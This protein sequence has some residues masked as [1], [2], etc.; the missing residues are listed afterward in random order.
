VS[1]GHPRTVGVKALP[2]PPE[3]LQ[4]N[5]CGNAGAALAAQSAAFYSVLKVSYARHGTPPLEQATILDF[6]CGWGRLTRLF[7][8][9][10][11]PAR[12][13]GC[14][15]DKEIL[16]WCDGLP[17]TFRQSEIRL[18][19]LPFDER[20]DLAFAFSVFTHLGPATH[21]SAL[22]AL[23]EALAPDGILIATIRPR[24]F[25]EMR[26]SE[27]A[28]LSIDRVRRLLDSYDA[29]E[30]VYLPY[31]LPPVEGEVPYGEAVVPDSYLE[32]HWQTRFEIL[33]RPSYGADP[34]QLPVVMRK[35]PV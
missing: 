7:A 15:S 10:V 16:K 11:D 30:Y 5:W 31:N 22:E 27:F 29:G 13:F 18:R 6:G 24:A 17:G 35:K 28:N 8:N 26:A 9:D 4:R 21:L 12:I 33:E 23:Y 25:L 14:D 3:S 32:K 2:E 1:F 19:K 20:F 34:M